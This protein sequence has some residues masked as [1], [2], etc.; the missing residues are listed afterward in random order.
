MNDMWGPLAIFFKSYSCSTKRLF[1]SSHLTATFSQ[2][3]GYNYFFKSH[4][5]T[6]YTLNWLGPEACVVVFAG[7]EWY[8]L[9]VVVESVLQLCAAMMLDAYLER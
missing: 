5:S 4:S 9:I 7:F 8:I 3:K 1:H 2:L 6:K